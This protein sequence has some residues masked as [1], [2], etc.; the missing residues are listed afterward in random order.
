MA[1]RVLNVSRSGYY[2]WRDRLPSMRD[3]EDAYLAN[4][5]VDIH[6]MSRRCYGAPRVHAELRF[7]SGRRVGGEGGSLAVGRVQS[8]PID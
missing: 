1:C 7:G 3:L 2:E 6:A 8:L 5:V 4:E